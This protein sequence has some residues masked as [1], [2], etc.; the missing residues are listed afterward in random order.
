MNRYDLVMFDMDGTLMDSKV[1]HQEV[2][3]RFLNEYVKPVTREEVEKGLGATV[4]EIFDSV[5]VAEE[6]L[7]RLFQKLDYFCKTQVDGLAIQIPAAGGVRE[8]LEVL[9]ARGGRT[10]L[11]TNSM[12]AVTLR[13]LV[14]HGLEQLFDAISG[15]DYVSIDK[16][17][18]C[19]RIEKSLDAR[20][21]LYV[22]DAEKDIELAREMGYDSCFAKFHFG[23]YG[24]ADYISCVMKPTYIVEK[25][26]DL[27]KYV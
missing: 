19:R 8:T 10:A 24:D 5:G 23:W 21:I 18:R 6:D 13:M 9:R 17:G 3:Y 1:F 26:T 2:F 11:L 22:G 16:T 12:E 20:R 27:L 14:T 7:Q 15:A 4:R 25:L